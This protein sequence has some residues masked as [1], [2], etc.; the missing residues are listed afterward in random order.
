LVRKLSLVA[1]HLSVR[2]LRKNLLEGAH[3]WGRKL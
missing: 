3:S 1:K 2:A